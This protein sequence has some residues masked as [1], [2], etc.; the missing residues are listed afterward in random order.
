MPLLLTLKLLLVKTKLGARVVVGAS[1]FGVAESDEPLLQAANKHT[2]DTIN[3]R[4]VQR[5]TAYAIVIRSKCLTLLKVLFIMQSLYQRSSEDS[6]PDKI[7]C[8][9][10]CL[11]GLRLYWGT[12]PK[13][14]HSRLNAIDLPFADPPLH[15]ICSPHVA[16][17]QQT[18][19][20]TW[21]KG[22][23]CNYLVLVLN[24]IIK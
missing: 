15:P 23:K 11:F 1:F 2:V 22:Y 7:N 20:T 9:R 3:T 17:S 8:L 19:P 14:R 16:H 24:T 13:F 5:V 10:P 4:E 18:P 21:T 12:N 6:A